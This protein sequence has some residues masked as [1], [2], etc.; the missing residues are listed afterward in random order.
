MQK[1][2]YKQLLHDR[3]ICVLIPTFNNVGTIADV[4]ERTL[5]Q[6]DDVIVVN[7][8]STDGTA[9]ILR[10]LQGITLVDYP[11]N[12][13]KGAALKEDS[14]KPLKWATHTP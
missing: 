13:G 9:E 10:N 6:C 3:G 1:S 4:V 11:V 5:L 2:H 14:R 8:G 12:A 7:D